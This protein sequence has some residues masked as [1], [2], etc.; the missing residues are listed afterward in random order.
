MTAS[1]MIFEISA[2]ICPE[3]QQ[4]LPRSERDIQ[5]VKVHYAGP[6]DLAYGEIDRWLWARKFHVIRH[7]SH[8]RLRKAKGREGPGVLASEPELASPV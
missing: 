1:R 8:A 4:H 7:V 6:L 3:H 2:E 5:L